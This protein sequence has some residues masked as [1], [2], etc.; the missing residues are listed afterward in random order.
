[1][2][3]TVPYAPYDDAELES[4]DLNGHGGADYHTI[5]SFVNALHVGY[6]S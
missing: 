6:R 2:N 5:K 1:L 4:G 3:G